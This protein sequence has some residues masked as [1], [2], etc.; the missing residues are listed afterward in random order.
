MHTVIIITHILLFILIESF[1]SYADQTDIGKLIL[2][3]DNVENMN[4]FGY[5]FTPNIYFSLKQEVLK[6]D[7]LICCIK[8]IV[9]M[10]DYEISIQHDNQKIIDPIVIRD[11][12]SNDIFKLYKLG[13]NNY[14]PENER[15]LNY[16]LEVNN[17]YIYK[18]T[19]ISNVQ[20]YFETWVWMRRNHCPSPN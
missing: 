15:Y 12:I 5:P 19:H 3:R 10:F 18:F 14:G 13:G 1:Q 2:V 4:E 7:E 6:D 11:K 20:F 17:K 9:N 16:K 8:N